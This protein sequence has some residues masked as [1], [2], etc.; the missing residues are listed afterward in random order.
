[1]PNTPHRVLDR[2]PSVGSGA[3]DDLSPFPSLESAQEYI[4]LLA[5]A[6]DDARRDIQQDIEAA[7]NEQADRRVEAL[8]LVSYKLNQLQNHVSAT[9]RLLNDLRMLRR[10][11]LAE[12][13]AARDPELATVRSR[14]Q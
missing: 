8:C 3:E 5:T 2:R 11:L 1:M 7:G 10:L 6:V 4:S 9:G 13:R 12:R 14:D